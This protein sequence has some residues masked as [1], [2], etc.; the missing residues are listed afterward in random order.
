MLNNF[1]TVHVV[2]SDVAVQKNDDD[3]RKHVAFTVDRNQMQEFLIWSK[4]SDYSADSSEGRAFSGTRHA[5]GADIWRHTI[6]LQRN[7]NLLGVSRF[8]QR[9]GEFW[10][11]LEGQIE[12]LSR[13]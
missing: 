4:L 6:F 8:E 2:K 10:R 3:K 13:P 7:F 5:E 12:E 1:A 11:F 9:T